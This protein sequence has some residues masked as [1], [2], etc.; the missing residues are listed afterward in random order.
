MIS[1]KNSVSWLKGYLSFLNWARKNEKS[2]ASYLLFLSIT[3]IFFFEQPQN[4]IV[5]VSDVIIFLVL[6]PL[7][8]FVICADLRDYLSR[9]TR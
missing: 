6:W 5:H 7:S 1:S 9:N 3:S 4:Y 2:R 8:A